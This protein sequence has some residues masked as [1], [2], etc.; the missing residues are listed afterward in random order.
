MKKELKTQ[1]IDQ[2][3]ELVK[4]YGNFYLTDVEGMPADKTSALRREAF[5]RDVKVVVVKNTLLKLALERVDG[6]VYTPLFDTLKGN[7]AVMFS[8]TANAPAKLIKD[9]TKEDLKAAAKTGAKVV[10]ALKSAYVQKSIFI[11]ANQLDALVNVKSKEELIGD[12]IFMLQSPIT[13]VVSALEGAA[14]GTIHGLLKS[15][16]EKNA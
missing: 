15:I 5:K 4:S 13:N 10:P 3:A 2:L 16:E 12:V 8:E 1:V 6:E 9:F 11:G 7:T 14:G